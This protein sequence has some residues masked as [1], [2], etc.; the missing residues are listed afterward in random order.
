MAR[1]SKETVRLSILCFLWELTQRYKI[2]G[3]DQAIFE[4][5]L[6]AVRNDLPT[7]DW[8]SKALAEKFE[9][10]LSGKERSFANLFDI[11]NTPKK[12]QTEAE[13]IEYEGVPL[14]RVAK[15]RILYK[16]AL[17]QGKTK[18]NET[19]DEIGKELEVS[20]FLV[21]KWIK[22]DAAAPTHNET[23]DLI[24]D[25]PLDRETLIKEIWG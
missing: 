8:V 25:I 14:S 12:L 19:Y 10:F 9:P 3:V 13:Q 2:L 24:G 7:P 6:I 23:D 22:G 4:A 18:V 21:K 1:M 17:E 15:A 16:E 5:N 11:P 20:S